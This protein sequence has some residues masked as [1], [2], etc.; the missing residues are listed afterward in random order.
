MAYQAIEQLEAEII[1]V[2][3]SKTSHLS[4][5]LLGDNHVKICTNPKSGVAS[6]RNYGA[7][8]A[9]GDILLFLDDDMLI[10]RENIQTTFDLHREHGDGCFMLNWI[11]PPEVNQEIIHTQFGRYLIKYGF[12]SLK[13]WNEGVYWNDSQL[14][15]TAGITSQYLSMFRST[16]IESG[17]YNEKFPHAGYEDFEFAQRLKKLTK[18]FYIYPLSMVYHNETDRLDLDAWLA[19]KRR[20]SET[21]KAA[22]RM[23]YSELAL[24]PGKIKKMFLYLL[25]LIKPVL[26]LLLRFIPN[27]KSLDVIYFKL[28]NILLATVIFEGYEHK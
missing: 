15:P 4:T 13:G 9:S 20:G 3:D 10:T 2:N 26:L 21:R 6:A 12:T 5:D 25:I 19:R 22:V 18:P 27:N 17:G 28:V 7:S 24:N 14:F 16:F 23:G 11:Y 1:V 8:M